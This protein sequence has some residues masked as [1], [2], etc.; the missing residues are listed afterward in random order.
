VGYHSSSDEVTRTLRLRATSPS[1]SRSAHVEQDLTELTGRCRD[2]PTERELAVGVVVILGHEHRVRDGRVQRLDLVEV[3]RHRLCGMLRLGGGVGFLLPRLR[4]EG[5]LLDRVGLV[6]V[7]GLTAIPHL[8]ERRVVLPRDVPLGRGPRLTDATEDGLRDRL[9]LIQTGCSQA[10]ER[11]HAVGD[12]VMPD[13]VLHEGV[14]D[15]H[16]RRFGRELQLVLLAA[17]SHVGQCCVDRFD[18][19]FELLE[20]VVI[21][22]DERLDHEHTVVRADVSEHP[23]DDR[24]SLVLVGRNRFGHN[25]PFCICTS[26]LPSQNRDSL[27]HYS[28]FYIISQLYIDKPP[29]F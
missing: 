4:V 16:R 6:G 21:A 23:A 19:A 14:L 1:G 12:L 3:R 17:R 29:L 27:V 24:G 28:I 9:G 20:H 8:V 2:V 7:G 10:G 15:L 25:A 18:A 13:D 26:T 22:A 11:T 5:L